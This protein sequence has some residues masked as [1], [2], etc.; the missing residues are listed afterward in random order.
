MTLSRPPMAVSRAISRRPVMKPAA[1]GTQIANTAR[2]ISRQGMG[3]F[4]GP[5]T[6]A[7]QSGTASDSQSGTGSC[8]PDEP[9]TR[10]LLPLPSGH[11]GGGALYVRDI[12]DQKERVNG[13]PAARAQ[14]TADLGA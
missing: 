5:I 12:C 3:V 7:S 9:L 1:S 13:V 14:R 2:I 4:F 6:L 8:P 10:E 11:A